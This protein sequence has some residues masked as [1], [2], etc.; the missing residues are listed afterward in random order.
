MVLQADQQWRSPC[1]AQPSAD[2]PVRT[3]P[4]GALG[5]RRQPGVPTT[6]LRNP[7]VSVSRR[8]G[9]PLTWRSRWPLRER[10]WLV[11][12]GSSGLPWGAEINALRGFCTRSVSTQ[13]ERLVR[14]ARLE[15]ATGRRP[16]EHVAALRPTAESAAT[17][18]TATNGIG[19]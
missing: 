3:R 6:S 9:T 18:A 10:S 15:I 17:N 16:V 11:V 1:L 12:S 2:D 5:G 8:C 13:G 7:T 14:R 19:P 4:P